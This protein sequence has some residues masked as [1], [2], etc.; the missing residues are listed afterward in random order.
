M[1]E[2][3]EFWIAVILYG[4]IVSIGLLISVA[5]I[6]I[7]IALKKKLKKETIVKELYEERERKN[8][9]SKGGARGHY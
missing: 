6:M 5:L 9:Q 8:G 2:D 3:Q 1:K 4:G 7:G